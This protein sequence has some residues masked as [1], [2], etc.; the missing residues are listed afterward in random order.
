MARQPRSAAARKAPRGSTDLLR[1]VYRLAVLARAVDERLWILS[2][3]G[4]ASFVLTP[5]GHE[6]AQIASAL[7]MR[8]G[9]DSAW[10]YYR[11]LAL[12]L[13]LG[14]SPYEVFLGALARADDP[15]SGG[16]QLTAHFSSPRL[17][18]GSLS[19]AVAAHIPHAVGAAY[20]ARVLGEESVAVCFFGEGATSAGNAHEAMNLAGVQRLPVVF[21]CENNGYAI[22]IPQSLQMPVASVADRGAAYGIPGL[23]V[24]GCDAWAVFQAIGDAIERARRGK[25][26]SL[27][28]LRVP[29]MTP[30]S[31]QD[32][33]SYRTAEQRAAAEAADPIARLRG[34]LRDIGALTDAED[35]ALVEET[36]ER[37]AQEAQRALVQPEPD[38]SRARTWLYAGDPPH[39]FLDEVER[40]RLL[41][42]RN[43]RA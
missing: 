19:S 24:D 20:A 26:P 32:D 16:R 37:V 40:G 4:E 35:E 7:A 36:R 5:R 6:V 41:P 42:E 34:E 29:R 27:V 2:R 17:R 39:P 3:Q 28:E 10:L 18:I 43:G 30:H 14:V 13:A 15:H 11:D 38:P 8:V 31:S 23:S 22:S 9:L 12:A 33:D 21:V 25:G 1:R